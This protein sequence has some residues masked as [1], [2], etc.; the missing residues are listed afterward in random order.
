MKSRIKIMMI[1]LSSLFCFS[2]EDL[3]EAPTKS[4]MDQMVIFSNPTFAKDVISSILTMFGNTSAHAASFTENYGCHNDVEVRNGTSASTISEVYR[5]SDYFTSPDNARL[6]NTTDAYS[7]MFTAIERANLAILGLRQYADLNN[8]EMAQ[9]LGEILA[10]RAVCYAELLKAWGNVPAR[11]EPITSE[12][13]YI[14]RSDRDVILKQML[15]DLEEASGLVGW[16]NENSY[17][18]SYQRISKA[19]TKAMRARV[20]LWAGGYSMHVGETTMR[21]SNDPD[22][23]REKMYAIAKQECLDVINSGKARLQPQGNNAGSSFEA[24]FRA[25]HVRNPVAGNENLWEIPF[26]ESRGRVIMVYGIR[27]NQPDAIT[28]NTSGGGIGPNPV[29]FYKYK[30]EDIRRDITC[31]PWE[32]TSD[33]AL[34]QATREPYQVLRAFNNWCFGK[35]RYEWR[36][37]RLDSNT[38]DG[39]PILYMRYANVLLMA[40]EAINELDG[41]AA[42]APYLRQIKERAYPNHTAIVDTEMAE[43]ATSKE[44]FFNAIV[45]ER[46]KELAGE[47]YRKEDL[48]RWN[49]LTVKMAENS[50]ELRKLS[51]REPPFDDVNPRL[52]YKMSPDG[53]SLTFW[54]L[55]RG[56]LGQPPL[57]PTTYT[58]TSR[59]LG[60]DADLYPYWNRLVAKERGDPSLQP[61][62]PIWKVIVDASN[63]MIVNDPVFQN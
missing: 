6:N 48:I 55:N 44:A 20:A 58:N 35:Y 43:A 38:I 24:A 62:W 8:W 28:A 63:G 25:V 31:I 51:F 60:S 57:E 7:S 21:M 54:G 26:S 39:T 12:T 41:P 11:F 4:T 61:Y 19:F 59:A 33:V 36:N 40:A 56:E 50:A 22:L 27:H 42:A 45:D 15:A 47:M 53:V 46:A 1:A 30:P 34:P 37:G 2:C 10:L 52:Y 13:M 23:A 14:P 16:P 9:I 29:L 3:L 18:T 49:L 5:L 17:T 32:W